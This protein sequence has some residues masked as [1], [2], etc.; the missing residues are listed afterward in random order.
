VIKGFLK[1]DAEELNGIA[2]E[3]GNFIPQFWSSN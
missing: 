1:R 3:E 2:N